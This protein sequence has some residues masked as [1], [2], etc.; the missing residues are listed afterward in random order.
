[1]A[2]PTQWSRR[3]RGAFVTLACALLLLPA[4]ALRPP[5]VRADSA[6]VAAVADTYVNKSS[7]NSA[8]GAASTLLVDNSP[9]KRTYLRFDASGVANA[10][11]GARLRVHNRLKHKAGFVVRPVLS[12]TWPEST[13]TW[14]NAPPLATGAVSSG[15]LPAGWVEL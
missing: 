4:L 11:V 13:T 6:T 2:A 12:V 14:N 7:P 8:N 15:S 1:M 5:G 3:R 9:V 10:V